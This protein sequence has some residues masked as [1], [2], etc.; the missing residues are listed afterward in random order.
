MKNTGVIDFILSNQTFGYKFTR[1]K[2]RPK[3]FK[4]PGW[5][6]NE[7]LFRNVFK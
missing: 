4:T 7:K 1:S 6:G 3:I 2:I 5:S